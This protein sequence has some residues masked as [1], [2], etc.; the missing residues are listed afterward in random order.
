MHPLA[1]LVH[2]YRFE[3]CCGC[4][5]FHSYETLVNSKDRSFYSRLPVGYPVPNMDIYLLDHELN[6]VKDGELG[7]IYISGVQ[8]PRAELSNLPS[9][10]YMKNPFCRHKDRKYMVRTFDY[11]RIK[12]RSNGTRVLIH[13][14][15]RSR[16]FYIDDQIVWLQSIEMYLKRLTNLVK[17]G[18]CICYRPNEDDQL[19]LAFCIPVSKQITYQVVENELRN[20]LSQ[21]TV[22]EV[23]IVDSIPMFHDTGIVDENGLLAIYQERRAKSRTIF[24]I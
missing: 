21:H 11:G 15:T 3:D 12:T 1:Q 22:P 13:E 10:N 18:H 19:I 8:L 9:H 17:V 7:E 2:M 16:H 14:M 4:C 5:A 6:P 20:I 23:V 24:F